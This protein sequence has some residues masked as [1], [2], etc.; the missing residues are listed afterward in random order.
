MKHLFVV[1]MAVLYAISGSALA[2][3]IP[4]TLLSEDSAKVFIGTVDSS[5]IGEKKTYSSLAVV[6]TAEVTPTIAIKGEVITG[7]SETH[8]NCDFG[9]LIPLENVEYLFCHIDGESLYA[10]EIEAMDEEHIILKGSRESAMIKRLEDYLNE[11]AFAMAEKERATLGTKMSFVEYLYKNPSFSS[12]SVEKVTFRYQGEIHEVNKDKF[13]EVAENIMI[14]N[15]KNEII[16]DERAKPRSEDSYDSIL[17]VELRG[18]D[19]SLIYFGAVTKY[20]EVDRYG[21]AMSRLM[22]KDYEMDSEDLLKLHSLIPSDVQTDKSSSD[23]SSEI[24]IFGAVIS[25]VLIV[26]AVL[27]ILRKKR[28]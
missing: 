9:T 6:K 15:V 8:E 16:R 21:M 20:G 11:G 7:V 24:Y 2:G 27:I 19:D 4:E 22:A 1:F 18:G 28:K 14:T 13:F 25:A 10:Y 17:F 12:S 23:S 26:S 3:D 5:T